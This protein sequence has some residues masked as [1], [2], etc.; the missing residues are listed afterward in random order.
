[1]NLKNVVDPNT[2]LDSLGWV[3]IIKKDLK[4]YIN[5][6]IF[7][8]T[9]FPVYYIH[10][11]P[12][13]LFMIKTLRLKKVHQETITVRFL[14][15]GYVTKRNNFDD[16]MKKLQRQTNTQP[17]KNNTR[18]KKKGLEQHQQFNEL[19]LQKVDLFLFDSN[20]QFSFAFL[21]NGYNTISIGKGDP[22][23]VNHSRDNGQSNTCTN[24]FIGMTGFSIESNSK[25]MIIWRR[26]F[27]RFQRR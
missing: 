15:I 5:L 24:W 1:M 23:S 16:K 11:L 20:P 9:F 12:V 6:Q 18:K 10:R 3:D 7:I 22:Q 19:Q 21:A 2:F 13:E 17:K 25:E 14:D 4:K 8:G 27:T 26:E